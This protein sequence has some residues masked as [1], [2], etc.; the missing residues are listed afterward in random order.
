MRR[1]VLAAYP[2]VDPDRVQVVHNGIDTDAVR[3]RPRHRRARPARHRPGPADASSSSAG[4]P[5]RRACPTCCGPRPR[6]RPT[7]SS[8]CS[9]ARRTPRRS[10]PRWTALVDELRATRDRRRLGAGDAAQARGHPGAHARDG[11]RLP[12]DLRAD[13]HRQ[14]GGDGLRDGRGR[15]R[16]RRHPR[17]GRRRRDRAAGADRAGRRRHRHAAGPGPVRRRPGRRAQRAAGGPGAR[18]RDGPGRAPAGGR[19]LLV[20]VDRRAD[21]GGLPRRPALS[22][23]SRPAAPRRW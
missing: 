13:G 18:R 23:G 7:R 4:S 21:D 19:P 22:A 6:C 14:P 2:G 1:D 15:D 9:P 11:V 16:D 17:G 8:S 10:P 20:G 3:A 12:V 5:A